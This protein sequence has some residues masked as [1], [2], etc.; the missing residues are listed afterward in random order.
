MIICRM[1]G[2]HNDESSAFCG[3]C[4]KFLEWSGEKVA[5][6]PEVVVVSK[7]PDRR[8]GGERDTVPDG[9]GQHRRLRRRK[10]RGRQPDGRSRIR[11]RGAARVQ[12]RAQEIDEAAR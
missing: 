10:V 2:N 8:S 7:T 11:L 1:C 4:G 5:P 12:L 3:D 6:P 9:F